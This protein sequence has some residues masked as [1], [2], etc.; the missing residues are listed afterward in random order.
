[1]TCY[2]KTG[3][4]FQQKLNN[5]L[6]RRLTTQQAM[7]AVQLPG[8][9]LSQYNYGLKPFPQNTLIA[10]ALRPW[11]LIKKNPPIEIGGNN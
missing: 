11:Q 6:C 7:I 3:R 4:L 9:Q 10:T 8:Q 2:L 1:M 5:V